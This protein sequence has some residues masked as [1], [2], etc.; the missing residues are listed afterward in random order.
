MQRI[1]LISQAWHLPRAIK[2]FEQ[3]GVNG[4]PL[5]PPA[6]RT[7]TTNHSSAGSRKPVHWNNSSIALKE[8][9]GRFSEQR[10]ISVLIHK[11]FEYG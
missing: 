2:L 3:Q 1:A 7:K 6:T 5:R 9:L 10:S 4:L 11:A 8:Y